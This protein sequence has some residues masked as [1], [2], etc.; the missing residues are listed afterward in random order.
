M[1]FTTGRVKG[2]YSDIL[3][4]DGGDPETFTQLCG[5]STR[6]LQVSYASAFEAEDYDCTD[7][8]AVAQ[9]L[10]SVG[11]QDWSISGNGLYNRTQMAAI[12]AL[13]GTTQNF[14]FAMDEPAAD[15]VDDGYWQGGGFISTYEVQ[16]NDGEYTQLSITITGTGILTWADAA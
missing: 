16:G 9:T 2:N 14:R 6:G 5:I 4:G 13:L 3:Y 11:A 12:R 8:E 1:A 7:P 15:S 10:R